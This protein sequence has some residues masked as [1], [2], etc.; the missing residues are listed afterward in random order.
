MLNPKDFKK[1]AGPIVE[2][3]DHYMN[4][5]SSFPVKSKVAPGDIYKAIP[6]QAPLHSESMKEIMEDLDSIILPGMTHWQHPGFH[7]YFPAN[8]SVESV[9][10]ESLT[11]AMGAQC[12]IWDTSPAA[13]ELEQRMME[14]LRDAMGIPAS[15]EGV[16][17]DSA[18]SASLVSLITAREVATGFRSNEEGVPPKLRIY[19]SKETHS[20]IEKGVAVCGIGRKNLVKIGVDQQMRMDPAELEA[21]IRKDLEA[22]MKPCAVVA[23]IGTTGTVAVDPLEEIAEICKKYGIWLHV[24]AAYAGSALL[25]PEY[26]WMIKGIEQADSFVFNPHKW[27]FT[28]FDCSV[29]LVKDAGLLIKTFEI[30][31]EYLKTKTRGVVNDYRDWGVPLG[32]RF[33]AL[34]LWFVIRSFGLEGI[35]EKL[36][37]HI[38]MNKRFSNGLK[39]MESIHL[40]LEPFLNFSCFRLQPKGMEGPDA[41]NRLNEAFQEEINSSGKLFL[42][43]T[44]INGIHTLRMLI[45]QTYVEESEVERALELIKDAARETIKRYNNE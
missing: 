14:W 29:Y 8:S 18:S 17:Q 7:A 28:N 27:M 15:F 19:C 2:W 22:G 30:L 40:P 3:I 5:I 1:E 44:K 11:S 4:H 20:S 6:E 23:T 37:S 31:P 25:L 42:T 35:R 36:R 41:L 34:K 13:A 39:K 38:R 10:A 26:R 12:M 33:R 45:G 21:M 16:I 9:L 32:R 24:D 43:H